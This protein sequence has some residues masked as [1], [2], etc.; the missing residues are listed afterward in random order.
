[1]A[2]ALVARNAEGR[3]LVIRRGIAPGQGAWAFP[4]GYVDDEETPATSAARECLEETGC[5]AVVDDLIG[6][7]HV[8]G[9][10]GPL[11]V[12]AYSGHLT[13]GDPTPTVEAP[14]LA[15]YEPGEIPPLVFSSH[16]QALQ[17]WRASL[18]LVS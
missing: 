9:E 1:V 10:E 4:G 12:L 3:V 7:F 6:V 13:G 18:A 11:V 2:V 8:V 16:R 5:V 17:A 15:W 14:E